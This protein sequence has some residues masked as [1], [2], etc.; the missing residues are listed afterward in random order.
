[1]TEEPRRASDIKGYLLDSYI[2]PEIVVKMYV[3][4]SNFII[5]VSDPIMEEV[6]EVRSEWEDTDRVIYDIKKSYT[7]ETLR[8][9]ERIFKLVKTALQLSRRELK[10]E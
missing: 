9:A 8:Q 3:N 10:N 6:S 1:M 7:C 5:Q 4:T 2:L